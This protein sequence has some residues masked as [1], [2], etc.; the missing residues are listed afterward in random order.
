MP[1]IMRKSSPNYSRKGFTLLELLV[2]IAIIG[3]LAGIMFPAATGALAKGERT[4]AENTAYN[5]K[6]AISAYFT[7]YRKYPVEANAAETDE[8]RTDT[9]LMNVLLGAD[10]EKA[11]GGLNPRGI[12][13]FTDKAAKPAGGGKFRKGIKLESDGGGELWDPYSE[14][15]YVRLDLDYN[16][17]IEKPDWDSG[18][19]EFLPESILVW[20]GGKD[21][22]ETTKKDNIKTW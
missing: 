4:H 16:N 9:E 11:R 17:R 20:S 5:L 15:Y 21:Q 7:E 19:S 8:L 3:V 18:D 1:R 14:Y 22:D 12:A 13:F 6:T 2:V 10:S